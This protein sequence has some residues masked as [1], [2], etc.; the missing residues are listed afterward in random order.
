MSTAK[1]IDNLLESFLERDIPG[2]SLHVVQNGK[3]LYEGYR[4]VTDI[5]TGKPVDKNSLFR[6]ASMSKIPM[7]TAMMMLYEKGKYLMTDPVGE[8]LPDWKTSSRYEKQA[9]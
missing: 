5:H 9:D 7:Y 6:L 2:C 8:Y 3:V 1:D 4:G